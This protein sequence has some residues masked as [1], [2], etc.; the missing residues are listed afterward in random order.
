LMCHRISSCRD[1]WDENIVT[2]A[3]KKSRRAL[4]S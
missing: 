3:A 1:P 2:S 4:S